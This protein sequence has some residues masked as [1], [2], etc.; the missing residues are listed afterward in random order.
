MP[1]ER[2]GSHESARTWHAQW[3][4]TRRRTRDATLG[5]Y[6]KQQMKLTKEQFPPPGPPPAVHSTFC[7]AMLEQARIRV[8]TLVVYR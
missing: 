3:R 5:G 4:V 7:C 6:L 2:P 1:R 8:L